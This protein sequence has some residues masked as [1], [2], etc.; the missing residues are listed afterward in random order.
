[1]PPSHRQLTPTLTASYNNIFLPPQLL[2]H[3]PPLPKPRGPKQDLFV[4]PGARLPTL[5]PWSGWMR[6]KQKQ[7]SKILPCVPLGR[8]LALEKVNLQLSLAILSSCCQPAA[9]RSHVTWEDTRLYFGGDLLRFSN[10]ELGAA[11]L[12]T[13]LH[14]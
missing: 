6:L 8:H 1:M 10:T 13:Q 14:I 2:N 4:T 9:E 5:A 11:L 3:Q 7:L 12:T